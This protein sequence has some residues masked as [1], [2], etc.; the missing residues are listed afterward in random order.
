[1]YHHRVPVTI[2]Q[3]LDNVGPVFHYLVRQDV[4]NLQVPEYLLFTDAD[5]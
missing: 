5:I 1:M 3:V 2:L 4:F